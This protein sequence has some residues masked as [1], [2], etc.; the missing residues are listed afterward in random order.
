MRQHEHL[1]RFHSHAPQENC[2]GSD[3]PCN[4]R[5]IKILEFR[6][7]LLHDVKVCC[8]RLGSWSVFKIDHGERVFAGLDGSIDMIEVFD[9]IVIE[10]KVCESLQLVEALNLKTS[11]SELAK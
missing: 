5:G 11:H 10:P 1:V 4:G 6:Q 3:L 2:W 7:H 8:G 9:G